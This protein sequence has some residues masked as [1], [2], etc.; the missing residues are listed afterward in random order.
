MMIVGRPCWRG[1]SDLPLPTSAPLAA[2]L[3]LPLLTFLPFDPG[4]FDLVPVGQ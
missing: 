2:L 4:A 3:T 1:E